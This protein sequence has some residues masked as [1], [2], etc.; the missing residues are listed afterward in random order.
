M[1]LPNGQI[2]IELDGDVTP[3]ITMDKTQSEKDIDETFPSSV[4]LTV[5]AV[6]EKGECLYLPALCFIMCNSKGYYCR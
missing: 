6:V 4:W 1:R 3:W 2:G 5:T